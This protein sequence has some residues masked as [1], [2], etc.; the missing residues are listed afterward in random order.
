MI[1]LLFS[2]SVDLDQHQL[3]EQ[4]ENIRILQQGQFCVLKFSFLFAAGS[5]RGFRIY[6][7]E[8]KYN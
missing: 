8:E 6:L 2:P 5:K 7:K 3:E 4:R 1:I